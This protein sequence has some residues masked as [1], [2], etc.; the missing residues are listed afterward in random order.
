MLQILNPFTDF[1]TFNFCNESVQQVN[2]FKL[3]PGLRLSNAQLCYGAQS[4][5]VFITAIDKN[6]EQHFVLVAKQQELQ[7]WQSYMQ[8]QG[9]ALMHSEAA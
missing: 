3:T 7:K 4:G 9:F 5:D 8:A 1:K 2:A 6:D